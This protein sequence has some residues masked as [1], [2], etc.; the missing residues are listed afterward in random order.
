MCRGA[1]QSVT[2]SGPTT[3][4]FTLGDQTDSF[5]YSCS[6]V[7]LAYEEA[8]TIVPISGDDVRGVVGTINLGFPFTFYGQA[9]T[10]AYVCT[11]GFLEFVGPGTGTC[12]FGN[13]ALPDAARPNG[14]I[15]PFWDDLLVDA[16]ASI[17]TDTFGSAPNRRFVIEWR[18]VHFFLDTTRRVDFNVVL[19]ENGQLVTQYRNLAAD[20][21]EQG[22]SA[23]IGIENATGATALQF[24]LNQAV[25]GA[26][27]A[28]TSIRYRPPT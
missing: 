19:H 13:E 28:V 1:R 24:S 20:G 25:L 4:N 3:L 9:Y 12:P 7:S 22:N 6:L 23:T 8:N 2:V 10:Q 27:P 17:R 26:E 14:A 15:Y 18:N 16:S 11:N 5:G 21:R